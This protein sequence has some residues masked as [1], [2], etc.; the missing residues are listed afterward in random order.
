MNPE[1]ELALENC[2]H[3]LQHGESLETCLAD[4]AD[5][6]GALRPLLVLATR[7]HSLPRPPASPEATQAG[8][9]KM[10]A[11]VD[12]RQQIPRFS[13]RRVV[14]PVEQ[15]L[16]WMAGT[17]RRP[18]G[19][20]LSLAW[21]TGLAVL[22]I[23][24]VGFPVAALAS[25]NS[26]PG[27]LLYPLKRSAEQVR[28]FFIA[29]N[30]SRQQLQTHYAAERR[31]E[32][33]AVARL[34]RQVT[35]EFEGDIE[36][37]DGNMWQVSGLGV[38]I[39]EN[40]VLEGLPEAGAHVSIRAHV[41]ADGTL[42]AFR[43]HVLSSPTPATLPTIVPVPSPSAVSVPPI[44]EPPTAP[45]CTTEAA[46]GL[47]ATPPPSATPVS[48]SPI[49]PTTT[50][51]PQQPTRLPT[52]TPSPQPPTTS[53]TASPT[54]GPP[55]FIEGIVEMFAD[56]TILVSDQGTRYEIT[57]TPETVIE[58]DPV[59]GNLVHVLAL[60]VPAGLVALHIMVIEP[61]P[62]PQVLLI[63]GNVLAVDPAMIR[64]EE[65]GGPVYDIVIT[66]ETVFA[67]DPAVGDLVRVE[68]E[69]ASDNIIRALFIEVVNEPPPNLV[70]TGVVRSLSGA[71]I[72]VEE[73]GG[74]GFE[75]AIT[76]ATVIIGEPAVGDTVLVE[77]LEEA[78]QLTALLIEVQN[79]PPPPPS[80][81]ITGVVQ[82]LSGVQI[83]VEEP[84]GAVF[85]IAITPA[86]VIIGEPAVGDT[87][88]VEAVE[89]AEGSVALSIEA[90]DKLLPPPSDAG[91][92]AARR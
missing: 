58:G 65:T 30:Q 6:S 28:L 56:G 2:L 40:T 85:A 66:P 60:P 35:V 14:N 80:L 36:T 59:A 68:A 32:A 37:I 16:S 64:V 13:W 86:T 31:Q 79:N 71:Q 89:A 55:V 42:I 48:P 19:R 43:V 10:L 62:P 51:T 81:V 20:R 54:S 38:L 75:I 27:E 29:D 33:Q 8:R 22:A 77:A 11:A 7:I 18:E 84:G 73:P 70:I 88:L 1:L 9:Q 34:R 4:Y 23:L 47:P 69:L 12:A 25:T 76:P 74:A 63:Q 44:T 49:R 90:L 82:S 3:R 17:L 72:I 61:S 87:V 91:D 45:P 83:I 92:D 24:L 21:R 26:L 15:F 78:G 52:A 67:G 53:P 41:R 5:Q 46:V 57:I 39:D 50:P